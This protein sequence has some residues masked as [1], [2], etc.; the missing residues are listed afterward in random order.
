[1]SARGAIPADSPP[2]Q[3][4]QMYHPDS[5]EEIEAVTK[6]LTIVGKSIGAFLAGFTPP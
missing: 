5:P 1:M 4:N 6:E 3:N 2:D